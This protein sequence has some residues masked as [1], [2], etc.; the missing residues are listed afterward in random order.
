MLASNVLLLVQYTRYLRGSPWVADKRDSAE[1]ESKS[2][3]ALRLKQMK[4]SEH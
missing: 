2:K 4:S 3:L 1:K